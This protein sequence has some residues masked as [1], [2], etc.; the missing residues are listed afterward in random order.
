MKA[1]NAAA[2]IALA[3]VGVALLRNGTINKIAKATASATES[4]VGGLTKVGKG[5]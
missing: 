3:I 5:I 2:T 1:K 4:T